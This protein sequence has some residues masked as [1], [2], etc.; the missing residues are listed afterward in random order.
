[1]N[2]LENTPENKAR[3]FAQ[4]W[5]QEVI[6]NT[7]G[8]WIGEPVNHNSMAVLSVRSPYL[9]L[10]PLSQISDEDCK[11]VFYGQ[12]TKQMVHYITHSNYGFNHDV[13]EYFIIHLKP[14]D[15][16]YLRSKGYAL[17]WMGLSVED[18][19]RYGWVKL[20]GETK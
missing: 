16:D 18:L 11:H 3:F 8:H 10:T 7:E 15:F 14:V 4:Y 12:T 9:E 17:P 6:Y 5:G 19:I 2:K 13:V 1:M 20:K